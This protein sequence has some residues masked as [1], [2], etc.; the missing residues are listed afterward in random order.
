MRSRLPSITTLMPNI[1]QFQ[2]VPHLPPLRTGLEQINV[3]P[4]SFPLPQVQISSQ[5]SNLPNNQQTINDQ[6]VN[7]TQATKE[8]PIKWKKNKFTPEEDKKLQNLIQ[9]YGAGDWLNISQ[10]MGTR[11]PRQCRE[12]WNNYLNPQLRVDPW[13]IEEDKTIQTLYTE[14]GAQWNTFVSF[15]VDRSSCDIKNRYYRFVRKQ[16]FDFP[17]QTNFHSEVSKKDD[18]KLKIETLPEPITKNFPYKVEDLLN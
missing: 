15:F 13:T 6:Y 9:K 2:F 7:T 16:N 14:Y 10:M 11:N 1:M 18:D 4:S 5:T 12:R 8:I 17:Q 3:C